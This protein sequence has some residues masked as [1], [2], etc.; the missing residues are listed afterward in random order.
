MCQHVECHLLLLLL[1]LLP[2]VE[3][4]CMHTQHRPGR[5]SGVD[6]TTLTIKMLHF[7]LFHNVTCYTNSIISHIHVNIT[8]LRNI[9]CTL[10]ATGMILRSLEW[11]SNTDPNVNHLG[12]RFGSRSIR[13]IDFI[14]YLVLDSSVVNPFLLYYTSLIDTRLLVQRWQWRRGRGLGLGERGWGRG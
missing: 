12:P 9:M 8:K 2:L 6:H 7:V 10:V 14:V 4:W 13:L 5:P 11:I 1:L 3:C